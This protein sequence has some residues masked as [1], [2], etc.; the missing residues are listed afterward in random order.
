M[1]FKQN[2]KLFVFPVLVSLG[3]LFLARTSVDAP[4]PSTSFVIAS[5]LF[6]VLVISAKLGQELTYKTG[7]K[8]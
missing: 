3:Y 2:L 4:E 7:A 5:A 1:E 6:L 8:K